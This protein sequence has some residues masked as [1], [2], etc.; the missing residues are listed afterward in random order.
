MTTNK[1]INSIW[2]FF[3]SRKC[4]PFLLQFFILLISLLSIC[5]YCF[6]STKYYIEFVGIFTICCVV[7]IR[8]LFRSIIGD[9]CWLIFSIIEGS[10]FVLG[11]YRWARIKI[12]ILLIIL[13]LCSNLFKLPEGE[14]DTLEILIL[15]RILLFF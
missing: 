15:G 10:K 11:I 12:L 13:L 9:D 3:F 2:L 5:W 1:S 8:D 4:T 14:N 6:L 7:F